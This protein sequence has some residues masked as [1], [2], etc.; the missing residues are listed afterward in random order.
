MVLWRLVPERRA[1][2]VW[3]GEGAR[4]YGGRWNNKGT[5]CVY[6][7]EHLSLSA[8]ETLV[9]AARADL[10]GRY[11]ACALWVPDEVT[12]EDIGDPSR[13]SPHWASAPDVPEL[14]AFGDKWVKAGRSALLRVPSAII[15]HES[16]FVL[17]VAHADFKRM[18]PQA[19]RDFFFDPRLYLTP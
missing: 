12:I 14:K 11:V 5:A 17:N 1:A 2:T 4:I 9:H 16:N 6:L 18:A 10:P 3:D 13:L 19:Q 7:S 8:L 15:P